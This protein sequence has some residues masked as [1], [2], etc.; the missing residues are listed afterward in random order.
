ML[1]PLK[2]IDWNE[3]CKWYEKEERRKAGKGM[4]SPSQKFSQSKEWKLVRNKVFKNKEK[5]CAYCGST[6]KL[7]VDHIKPKSKYKHLALDESN[8]QI[9]CMPCNFAKGAKVN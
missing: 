6:D 7:H 3:W 5:V 1:K 8:L 2:R 9:L 4:P